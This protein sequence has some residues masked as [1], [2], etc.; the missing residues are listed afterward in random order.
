F[1][2][3]STGLF[4]DGADAII[5]GTTTA[6]VD[7]VPNET[8]IP[9]P[10]TYTSTAVNNAYAATFM[11]TLSGIPA[12]VHHRANRTIIADAFG[13]L[14]TPAGTYSNTLRLKTH[15]I[16][17]DSIFVMGTNQAAYNQY[18]TT[19][20]YTWLQNTQDAQL[21]IIS[22]DKTNPIVTKASYL[23][24]FGIAGINTIK[25]TELST[26]LYPNP[27]SGV[28][29]LSYENQTSSNVSA[30]IFDITGRQV[31]TLINNQQQTAGKQILTVDVNTLQLPLGLYMVQLTINGATKTL[32][33]NVQ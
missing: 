21:L 28:T 25:H 15:E 7:Y 16:T 1:I 29:Y 5:T 3:G 10:Y 24:S 2:S 11:L 26:N 23:Q 22:M 32:K 8:L 31:A 30:S 13:S 19:T 9:V 12:T 17:S 20:T 27:T 14:T 6:I 18:D 33:L 4:V